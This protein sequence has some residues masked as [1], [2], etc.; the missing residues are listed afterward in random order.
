VLPTGASAV[1]ETDMTFTQM[2]LLAM[3]AFLIYFAIRVFSS[4]VARR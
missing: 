4:G 1:R 2:I 3:A